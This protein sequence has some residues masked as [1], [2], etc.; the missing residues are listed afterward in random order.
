MKRSETGNWV[1][2]YDNGVRFGSINLTCPVCR[3][4]VLC[5]KVSIPRKC[6]WCGKVLKGDEADGNS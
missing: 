1:V 5:P 2:G 6:A 4:G 3:H